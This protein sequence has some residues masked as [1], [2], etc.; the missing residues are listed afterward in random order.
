MN[1][2]LLKYLLWSFCVTLWVTVF[3]IL[4]DFIDN[5]THSITTILIICAYLAA[6]GLASY[7]LIYLVGLQRHIAAVLIPII[8]ISGAIVSYFRV[9]FHA[10]ITPMIVDATLHTNGGTIA[11]VISWQFVVWLVANLLISIGF[12]LWRYRLQDISNRW[13]HALLIISLAIGY[14]FTSNRLRA[15][16]NQRFPY[17]IAY[18]LIE[19]SKQQHQI[20]QTRE[21]L[22]YTIKQIPDSI[23]LIFV[24]GEA[25]RADH[26]QLN[27][28]ER[29]TTPLLS[30][31]N[32]VISLPHIYSEQTYTSNSVPYILSPADSLHPERSATH[33]SFIRILQENHF[34]SAWLSNQDNGQTYVAF[35]HEADTI[36]FPN[37][38]KST[39]VF[40]P[41]YDEQLLPPLD[42]LIQRG[43][44]RQLYVLHSIG[45]HW[46]YNYHV[47]PR[48][49][50]FQPQTKN[51]II[52]NN[53][54][55]QIRNSY[56]NTALYLDV[57]LDSLIQRFEHRCAIMI[58]LSDHGEALGE[59]GNYLHASE[60]EALHFPACIIWYS[61]SYAE[62]FPE[63]V[64]VIRANSKKR[65]R[66]DFLY[67]SILSAAGIE[68]E[69][70]NSSVNIFMAQ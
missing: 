51:R 3:F 65:Y 24:I 42:E 9:A 32:N 34:Q 55:L 23:D 43:N 21:C 54:E 69:G 11:G 64:K 62:L 20:S 26:L 28:Y 5:P 59:N 16:I 50:T 29:K 18:S 30:S 1:K 35:I 41:W 17:N 33:C 4:P 36:I 44:A 45:S 63:K 8:G 13:L 52:T 40:A 66:T 46:Y 60:S 57:F 56:D 49:Q 7:W 53:D 12:L 22:P 38:S 48:Y 37:A 2:A 68:S 19:Y 31:R 15:S 14:Y 10:T 25:M 67:Y 47:P 70:S 58:Y 6:L 39:Y 61:D 27:G